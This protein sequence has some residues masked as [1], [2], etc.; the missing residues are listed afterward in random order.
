MRSREFWDA[1]RLTGARNLGEEIGLLK[2]YPILGGYYK[3]QQREKSV[4]IRDTFSSLTFDSFVR[5]D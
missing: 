3:L 1:D 5:R 2:I 4:F